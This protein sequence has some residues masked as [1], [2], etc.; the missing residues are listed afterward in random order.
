M[1]AGKIA[2]G[3][4]LLSLLLLTGCSQ[5]TPPEPIW[6]GHLTSMTGPGKSAGV[7]SQA[8]VKL[9]VEDFAADG[10]KVV[11]RPVAV[12]HVDTRGDAETARVE[13]GR[14]IAVNKV[15]ALLTAVDPASAE[16]IGRESLPYGVPVVVCGELPG[17]PGE[18]V[19]VVGAG[20]AA[21]GRAL[22]RAAEDIV[23]GGPVAVLVDGRDP[24]AGA[25]ASAFAREYRKDGKH[26][27]TVADYL[28]ADEFSRKRA[29][30]V[31][32]KFDAVL[33]AGS[34]E[35]AEQL[36]NDLHTTKR[37]CPLLFGGADGVS[38]W[39][40]IAGVPVYSATAF[41][42]EELSE[43]GGAFARRYQ[44]KTGERFDLSAALAVDATNLLFE[45]L[46]QTAPGTK[47]REQLAKIETLDG[48]TG[49]LTFK[50]RQA[51][52]PVFVV[53]WKGGAATL[54]KK[55]P[56]EQ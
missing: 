9:D 29:A 34:A 44:E 14:L 26:T 42:T 41:L 18:N 15:V 36:R 21:R 46:K 37:T 39:S 45:A 1:S 54:V 30:L 49:A 22:A 56:A 25:L 55:V 35:D 40:D 2:C 50:D 53:S 32:Q 48:T 31:G 43:K 20:P 38:S 27:A 10:F 7:A 11:G 28:N 16:R 52:R 3:L 5:K 13:A 24:I 8:A 17:P 51:R 23:K 47:L 12:R 19:F 6:V 33:L 4:I